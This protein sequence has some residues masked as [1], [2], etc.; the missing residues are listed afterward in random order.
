MICYQCGSVIGA[1]KHC[2]HCG[3]NVSLYRKI[4]KTSN[5]Y[6]NEGLE[7]AKIRDLSG[8]AYALRKSLEYDK[9]NIKARNLLG[10][11]YYEM[12]EI[13]DA[14]GQWIISN[15]YQPGD[16]NASQYIADVQE[17]KHFFETATSAIKK[18]NQALESAKNDSEDLAIIQLKN[19]ISSYPRHI[20]AYQLLTLLLIKQEEYSKAN[21]VIKKALK[22]DRANT[23]ILS[24]SNEIK[25]KLGRTKHAQASLIDRTQELAKEDVIIPEYKAP[26]KTKQ[27]LIG[28]AIAVG[29]CLF[30]Y[31]FLIKPSVDSSV[32]NKL[33]QNEIS[34]YEQ[35][36]EKDTEITALKAELEKTKGAVEDGEV[37]DKIVENYETL[38]TAV[39][40]YM[41]K[42][43][44]ALIEA[45]GKIDASVFTEE[46][47]VKAYGIL[48]SYLSSDEMLG[49][50]AD[51]AQRV[52]ESGD[53]EKCKELCQKILDSNENQVKAIYYMALAIEAQGDDSGASDYFKKIVD[54]FPDSEY[55]PYAKLRVN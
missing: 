23:A 45:F 11:V 54:D 7:K 50:M 41:D 47:A 13:V 10:L 22:L 46:K 16:E 21:K 19:A 42:D 17:D 27:L 2:L 33:N 32:K 4:V 28:G 26:S 30:T 18:F 34:Y 38:L 43:D 12:G 53:Y 44:T 15:T 39:N 5:A 29:I 40:C 1:G 48:K 20:K 31:F 3:A 35:L 55:A 9:K 25:G 37:K 49:R 8:A 36:E 14:L 52:Y 6:Y 51:Q 24:Y